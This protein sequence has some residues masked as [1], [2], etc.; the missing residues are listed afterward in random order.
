MP[1]RESA[2][3]VTGQARRASQDAKEALALANETDNRMDQL[4][5]AVAS[6]F[7]IALAKAS[8]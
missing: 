4:E 6:H 1:S 3:N 7:G 5:Q 2:E 8:R